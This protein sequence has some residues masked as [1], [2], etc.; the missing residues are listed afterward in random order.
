M[1]MAAHVD[2]GIAGIEGTAATNSSDYAIG[3]FRMLHTLLFV[4]GFWSYARMA[5]LV[6]FIFYKAS[7]VAM[8]M[9][10]FGFWSGFSGTQFFDDPPYQLYNV[11]Y[12]ALPVI[13]CAVMDRNL[14]ANM[15]ENTPEAYSQQKG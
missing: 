11:V 12:T 3:T 2:V 4:H 5:T 13:A 14:P 7:M 15:L 9:Y 8:T 1:I 6:N 10:F